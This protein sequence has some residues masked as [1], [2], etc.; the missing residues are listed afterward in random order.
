MNNLEQ[1]F[2]I[3]YVTS[4]IGSELRELENKVYQAVKRNYRE[5]L[6]VLQWKVNS[7]SERVISKDYTKITTFMYSEETLLPLN[8]DIIIFERIDE[9][10]FYVISF[11]NYNGKL[12]ASVD[13]YICENTEGGR[14]VYEDWSQLF[15]E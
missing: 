8:S 3:E 14:E 4:N 12:A 1:E 2:Y 5:L 15:E 13:L 10:S 9:K 11:W 7:C 6:S